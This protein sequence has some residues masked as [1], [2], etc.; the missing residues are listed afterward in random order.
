L[1]MIRQGASIRGIAN[2]YGVSEA[3][4]EMRLKTT[5]LWDIRPGRQ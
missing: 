2:H 5:G 3:A 1:Q 4:V